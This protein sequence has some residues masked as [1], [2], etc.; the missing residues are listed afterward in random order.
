QNLENL[1]Q[2]D[3]VGVLQIVFNHDIC[4]SFREYCIYLIC[5]NPDALFNNPRLTQLDRSTLFFILQRDDMG[6]LSEK[7]IYDCLIKWGAAQHE[8]TM[9]RSIMTWTSREFVIFEKSIDDF[10]P[11]IRWFTISSKDFNQIRYFLE[12]VLPNNLYQKLVDYHL[13]PNSL[14]NEKNILP[15]RYLPCT[16]LLKPRHFKIFE[17]WIEEGDKNKGFFPKL[18]NSNTTNENE[19]HSES[20]TLN[21]KPSHFSDN[22]LYDFVLL[23]RGTDNNF[24]VEEFHNS[25]DNKGPTLTII[26]TSN[27]RIFGGYNGSKTENHYIER[28]VSRKNFLFSFQDQNDFS[29]SKLARVKKNSWVSEYQ[30]D[31]GPCFGCNKNNFDMYINSKNL[32]ISK[33]NIYPNLKNFYPNEKNFVSLNSAHLIK[34]YEVWH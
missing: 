23:Y 11:L 20:M 30:S 16:F 6:K 26:K 1:L 15:D 32:H 27:E 29:T 31:Y 18:F 33:S 12:N 19:E 13:D 21:V 24:N 25:C 14:L 5:L 17:S 7:K 2:D 10:I 28:I 34:D 22:N 3:A 8:A 4:E 9:L